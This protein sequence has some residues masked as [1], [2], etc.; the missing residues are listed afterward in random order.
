MYRITKIHGSKRGNIMKEKTF[1]YWSEYALLTQTVQTYRERESFSPKTWSK[2]IMKWSR[3][4]YELW[5]MNPLHTMEAFYRNWLIA[6]ITKT[7]HYSIII[8]WIKQLIIVHLKDIDSSSSSLNP[9]TKFIKWDKNTRVNDK[10]IT[11][12]I[13]WCGPMDRKTTY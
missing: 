1:S 11:N 9:G 12:P 2:T 4:D 13:I 10:S 8:H 5:S 6:E 3:N 7:M